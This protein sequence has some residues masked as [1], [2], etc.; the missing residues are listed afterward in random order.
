MGEN[1]SPLGEAF[2]WWSVSLPAEAGG[3]GER[4]EQGPAQN[5]GATRSEK[6]SVL[7]C[8]FACAG[9]APL[10]GDELYEC[11]LNLDRP[12][13]VFRRK[14]THRLYGG[15]S[16]LIDFFFIKS[17]YQRLGFLQSCPSFLSLRVKF[18]SSS[19]KERH[20]IRVPKEGPILV[21]KTSVRRR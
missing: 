12:W 10:H 6:E 13:A 16:Q 4:R 8:N 9:P 2:S 18:G 1:P 5:S 17:L 14:G 11:L 19:H 7:F 15:G 3:L 21:V 20:P